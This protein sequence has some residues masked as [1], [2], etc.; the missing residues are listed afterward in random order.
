MNETLIEGVS[1]TSRYFKHL[2]LVFDLLAQFYRVQHRKGDHEAQMVADLLEKLMYSMKLLRIRNMFTQDCIFESE[3]SDSGF[4]HQQ[5]IVEIGTSIAIKESMLNTLPTQEDLKRRMLN[6]IFENDHGEPGYSIELLKSMC[7]RMYYDKLDPRKVFLQIIPGKLLRLKASSDSPS[8]IYLFSWGFYDYTANMPYI[9]VLLFEQSTESPALEEK[10]ENYES[11]LK[12]ISYEGQRRTKIAV[13]ASQIDKA[14]SDLSPKLLKRIAIGPLYS[15]RYSQNIPMDVQKLFKASGDDNDFLLLFEQE[16]LVSR[17]KKDS[18]W[19]QNAL[20]V[21]SLPKD[22]PELLE[23]MASELDKYALAP[24]ELSQ[25]IS[26]SG[27]FLDRS[28][29][30][31]DSEGELYVD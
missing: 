10:M 25:Q 21:F 6:Y 23:R 7:E 30:L 29:L 3:L 5:E 8:R 12:T 22:D 1:K 28:I 14:H 31:C 13:V 11:F 20:Q 27:K 2:K 26:E 18:S 15:E 9:N 16:I 4:P 19:F 17:P 24:H